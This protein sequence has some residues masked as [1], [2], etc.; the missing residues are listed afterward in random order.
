MMMMI[1]EDGSNDT[2]RGKPM[3]CDE[4]LPLAWLW[5]LSSLEKCATAVRV[6][7]PCKKRRNTFCF[8]GVQRC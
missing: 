7:I 5:W 2:D 4:H 6:E 3:Y 1:M 8:V